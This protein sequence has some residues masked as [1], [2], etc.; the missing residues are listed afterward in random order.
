LVESAQSYT[1][2][3]IGHKSKELKRRQKG[4][5]VEDIAEVDF[6][7]AL[8]YLMLLVLD[9]VKT[10]EREIIINVQEF[11]NALLA[12]MCKL[13]PYI[14]RLLLYDSSLDLPHAL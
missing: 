12:W 9:V 3:A 8:R 7:V 13:P 10:G 4:N 2:G 5:S 6:K 14:R 11:K 1:R